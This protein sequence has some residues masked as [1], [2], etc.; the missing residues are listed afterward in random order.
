MFT[1]QVEIEL[2]VSDGIAVRCSC[3]CVRVCWTVLRPVLFRSD[4]G[5][6]A[7]YNDNIIWD[8]DANSSHSVWPEEFFCLSHRSTTNHLKSI[9]EPPSCL[10]MQRHSACG[11]EGEGKPQLP[12]AMKS[13][14]S[15]PRFSSRSRSSF[16]NYKLFLHSVF[17]L[18]FRM[19]IN[20]PSHWSI[21]LP[22]D[23]FWCK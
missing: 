13:F 19:L 5:F 21:Q 22:Y 6:D 1:F 10:S 20:Q 11:H 16:F 18:T 2:K 8:D 3:V 23:R 17:R 4:F 15:I 7:V 12:G 9:G 14:I